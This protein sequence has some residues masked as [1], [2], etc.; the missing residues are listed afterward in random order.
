MKAWQNL[1]KTEPWK[2]AAKPFA[3]K[4]LV[5]SGVADGLPTD[6]DSISLKFA[7]TGAVTAKLGTYSCSSVLIPVDVDGS[8]QLFLYFPPKVGKFD[9]YAMEVSLVWDGENFTLGE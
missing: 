7:A 3:N 4:T 8:Y 6:G 1:W 2:S 5:L 9:G